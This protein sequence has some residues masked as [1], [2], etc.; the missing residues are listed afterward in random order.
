MLFFNASLDKLLYCFGCDKPGGRPLSP[1]RAAALYKSN[2]DSVCW[3]RRKKDGKLIAYRRKG[4]GGKHVKAKAP[5]LKSM[6]AKQIASLEKAYARLARVKGREKEREKIKRVVERQKKQRADARKRG[7]AYDRKKKSTPIKTKEAGDGGGG[8]SEFFKLL[9]KIKKKNNADDFLTLS[10]KEIFDAAGKID[11][12]TKEK[13]GALI[14]WL[15]GDYKLIKREYLRK[16][17]GLS[18]E[19]KGARKELDSFLSALEDFP[20]ASGTTY[21][22]LF[23]RNNTEYAPGQVIQ[24]SLDSYRTEDGFY[25][26]PQFFNPLKNWEDNSFVTFV[27][28][29]PQG[30]DLSQ[31]NQYER[32]VVEPKGKFKIKQVR[33][34]TLKNITPGS[35]KKLGVIDESQNAFLEQPHTVVEI[36][37]IEE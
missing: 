32:E 16:E 4:E 11:K 2:R 6:T 18:P 12:K 31:I 8:E 27:L 23:N 36:E 28:S 21:R 7:K 37:R 14:S 9:K 22:T 26:P 5:T 30:K 3:V 15:G 29:N 24:G 20:A 25:M 10:E 13:I 34:N 35:A 17:Q 1:A 19:N 33:T